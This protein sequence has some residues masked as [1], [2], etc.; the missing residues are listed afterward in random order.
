[1]F[2]EITR[3]DSADLPIPG[4]PYG[5]SLLKQA[6]ARGDQ[7]ALESRHSRFLRIHLPDKPEAALRKIAAW[8][9]KAFLS[10]SK[11]SAK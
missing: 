3:E 4:L 1:L 11:Q 6:Q 9:E 10:G 5:F 7:E 2:V 8:V